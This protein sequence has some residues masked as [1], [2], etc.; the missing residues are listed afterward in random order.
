[1]QLAASRVLAEMMEALKGWKEL[2]PP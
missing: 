2:R 1:M